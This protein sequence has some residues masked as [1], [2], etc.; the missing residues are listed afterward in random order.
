MQKLNT[1]KN[2]KKLAQQRRKEMENEEGDN[3]KIKYVISLI[4]ILIPLV[5]IATFL[6]WYNKY[7]NKKEDELVIKHIDM[8]NSRHSIIYSD[9]GS[10]ANLFNRT[11]YHRKLNPYGEFQVTRN[12]FDDNDELEVNND[13]L[14]NN[15]SDVA[16]RVLDCSSHSNSIP[17]HVAESFH[18]NTFPRDVVDEDYHL[19]S[20]PRDVINGSI[21]NS[22]LP[23]DVING[24]IHNSSLPR[25]VING[26]IHNSSLPRDAINGSIH[27]SSLPRD[28]INGSIHNSSLP[29]DAINGSIH[30]N[31]LPRD[32]INDSFHS[33]PS[34]NP[35]DDSNAIVYSSYNSHPNNSS[36][37]IHSN[38]SRNNSVNSYTN[39]NTSINSHHSN[40]NNSLHSS[41]LFSNMNMPYSHPNSSSNSLNQ[42]KPQPQGTSSVFKFEDQ[43]NPYQLDFDNISPSLTDS[44]GNSLNLF[45]NDYSRQ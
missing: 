45:N 31:S 30:N 25:D 4:I 15:E 3:S 41:N 33:I 7:S 20:L 22:S 23:R 28:A 29:R 39:P 9:T 43:R 18:Q 24:S 37:S 36:Q 27:N 11:P 5:S 6:H 10:D 19:N 34:I 38:P 44:I 42:N 1:F 2:E 14:D 12:I 40:A 35:F 8:M 17:R 13:G 26:S 32:A 16:D 21:H